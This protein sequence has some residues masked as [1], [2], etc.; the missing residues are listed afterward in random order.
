VKRIVL[1]SLP[2]AEGALDWAEVIRQVVRRPL[3]PQRGADIP[4]MRSSIRV[5]DALD[6]AEDGL[7]ELEDAD[8]EHLKTK[9]QAM[10]WAF[11]DRRIMAF[12]DDIL[13]ATEQPSLNG[14]V[15]AVEVH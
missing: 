1:R 4:E 6:R 8:Y 12:V 7:L 5:L 9:T 15:E 13:N 3:D 10:Q 14:L 2:G 11:I